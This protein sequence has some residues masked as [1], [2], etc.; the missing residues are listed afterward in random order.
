MSAPTPEPGVYHDVPYDEYAAWG[1]VNQSLLKQFRRSPAHARWWM[2]HQPEPTAA[3]IFGTAVHAAVLEPDRFASEYAMAPQ[4]DRRTKAGR[5]EWAAF[6]ADL[7]DGTVLT[8]AEYGQCA[9]MREA[10]LRHPKAAALLA[11]DGRSEVSIL[12]QHPDGPRGKARLDRFTRFQGWPTVVDLKTTRDAQ[13]WAFAKQAHQLGYH[14]QAAYTLE[15]LRYLSD[16]PRRFFS[17][18]VEKAPPYGVRVYEFDEQALEQG[19]REWRRYLA[20]HMRATEADEWPG[21]PDAIEPLVLPGYA[22]DVEEMQ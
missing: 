20:A 8:A 13:P 10:V 7:G 22:I 18:A 9:A 15:G 19:E 4:V 2:T 17:V 1:A 5:E 14:V 11:G 6:L 16:V 3:M 21:Y 12:W